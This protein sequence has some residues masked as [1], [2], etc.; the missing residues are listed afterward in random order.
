MPIGGQRNAGADA[1]FEDAAADPLGR[2]DRLTA[3]LTEHR[4]EDE[5]V[6]GGPAVIGGGDPVRAHRNRHQSV[7]DLEHDR[8]ARDLLQ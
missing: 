2:R 8:D 7:S 6:G 1:H 5:I 4:P 3:A